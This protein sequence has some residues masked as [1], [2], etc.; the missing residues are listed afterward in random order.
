MSSRV[1]VQLPYMHAE[2]CFAEF[3]FRGA[4]L[5]DPGH[6]VGDGFADESRK[7]RRFRP[8]AYPFA[9]PVASALLREMRGMD[10]TVASAW[11]AIADRTSLL[12]S[13]ALDLEIAELVR[14]LEDEDPEDGLAGC[15]TSDVPLERFQA[16]QAQKLLLMAWLQEERQLEIEDLDRRLDQCSR[17]MAT[18]LDN[19]ES[20]KMET[21]FPGPD[22]SLLA[23]WR[24]V[25]E[26]ALFF[27]PE[28]IAV[29]ALGPLR[30]ALLE[31]LEFDAWPAGENDKSI[32]CTT[33][34]LWMA[35]GQTAPPRGESAHARASRVRRLWLLE[36]EN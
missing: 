33:A 32:L 1:I 12:S 4:R 14:L 26:N 35:L 28:N 21:L 8:S 13:A 34:P 31:R 3:V 22:E 24:L 20:E 30:E 7:D 18:C 25:V 27:L 16:E 5:L 17:R 15:A 6:A 23:H 10:A 29:A 11:L 19:A 36:A 2:G 9:G